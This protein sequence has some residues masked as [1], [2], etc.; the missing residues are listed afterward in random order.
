MNVKTVINKNDT[1]YTGNTKT[2][3]TIIQGEIR[4]TLKH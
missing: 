1:D 4:W 3:N 2:T